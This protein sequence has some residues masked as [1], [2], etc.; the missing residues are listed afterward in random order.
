VDPG[1]DVWQPGEKPFGS[2]SGN[3]VI[4]NLLIGKS[5]LPVEKL[6]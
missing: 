4:K 3:T 6:D 5:L 1:N 2:F